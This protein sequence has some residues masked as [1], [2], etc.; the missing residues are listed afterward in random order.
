MRNKMKNENHRSWISIFYFK[1][2][3]KKR[4]EKWNMNS[5]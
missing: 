3:K 2:E 4:G 5:Q 1:K